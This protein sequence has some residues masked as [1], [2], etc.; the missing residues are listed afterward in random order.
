MLTVVEPGIAN[1]IQDAGRWG[2]QSLGV[3]VSGAMDLFAFSLAN[4]LVRNARDTAALEIHAPLVLQTDR[5]HLVAVT[6]DARM[7]I[8]ERAMPTWMSVFARGGAFIEIVPTSNWVYLAIHGGMAVPR[9]MNSCATYVRGEFGGLAGR[10]LMLGAELAVGEPM[11]EELVS[12][13]G[14]GATEHARA[15]AQRDHAIRVLRGPHDDWFDAAAFDALTR[16]EYSV[17]ASADRMGYRLRGQ[18]LA[19]RAGELVSCGVPLGALQV[20]ADAQPIALMADHQTTG[21]YPIIATIIRADM[22]LLA[23][24][25]TGAAVRFQFVTLDEAQRASNEMDALMI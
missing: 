16:G 14:R 11:L 2:Y 17:D 1:T 21:G 7:T 22:A 8:N 13:A 12:S 25:K 5:P 20:P 18:P 24:K 6:G 15:F 4:L 3:P 10:A 9:V 19:R 23:Q